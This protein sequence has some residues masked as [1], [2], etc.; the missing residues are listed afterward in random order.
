V[1]VAHSNSPSPAELK[2]DSAGEPRAP[3]SPRK[4]YT[5]S[6][7]IDPHSL[8]L[9]TLPDGSSRAQVEFIAIA[10]GRDGKRLNH[11]DNGF[12]FHLRADQ[13]SAAMQSGI[14]RQIELDLPPG[15]LFLRVAVHDLLSNRIGSTEFPLN[16]MA[17]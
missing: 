11:S 5:L 8:G 7:N 1:R 4:R 2:N 16:V 15:H 12:D 9:N 13:H 6:F 14:P 3:L 17:P 10:Y